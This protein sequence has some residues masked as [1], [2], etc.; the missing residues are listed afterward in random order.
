MLLEDGRFRVAAGPTGRHAEAWRPLLALVAVR[1][2]PSSLLFAAAARVRSKPAE[3]RPGRP[4]PHDSRARPGT[5]KPCESLSF[6]RRLL[7]RPAFPSLSSESAPCPSE[8]ALDGAVCG[9]P[10]P[11]TPP[12]RVGALGRVGPPPSESAPPPSESAPPPSESAPPSSESAPPPSESAPSGLAVA[13]LLLRRGGGQRA[14]VGPSE[15]GPS[16]TGPGGR[17]RPSRNPAAR[18]AAAP[19]WGRLARAC[20]SP[21]ALHG[22]APATRAGPGGPTRTGPGGARP[23]ACVMKDTEL[24]KL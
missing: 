14:R 1:T 24:E 15:S 12:L 7:P 11:P 5:T 18:R 4:P 2:C 6:G 16:T 21:A 10:A 8:L 22:E 17:A 20:P 19:C 23:A 13:V 9:S 3:S